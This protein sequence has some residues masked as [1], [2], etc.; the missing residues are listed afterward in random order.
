MKNNKLIIFLIGLFLIILEVL[1]LTNFIFIYYENI[2]IQLL[3]PFIVAGLWCLSD[4]E[5]LKTNPLIN[6]LVLLLI[7]IESYFG[8][9]IGIIEYIVV[10][11][12]IQ[13]FNF[14]EN[15]DIH[16][17]KIALLI[18][19]FGLLKIINIAVYQIYTGTLMSMDF[20]FVSAQIIEIFLNIVLTFFFYKIF[21]KRYKLLYN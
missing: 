8:S 13:K 10:W 5:I 3:L 17:I 18:I 7:L 14:L 12:L 4:E 11:A 21:N 19:L 16:I 6:Y 9:C 2:Q 1:I 20:Q 15:N